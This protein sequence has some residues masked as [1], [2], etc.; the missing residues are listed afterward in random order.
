[1]P[2]SDEQWRGVYTIPVTPFDESGALDRESLRRCVEFCVEAGAHG[3]VMPVNASEFFTLSDAERDEV[4]RLGVKAADGAAPVIAGVSGVSPEHAVERAK[5]AEEAGAD[6][7][8]ALPPARVAGGENIEEYYRVLGEAL[9]VPLFIQ[10][11]NPPAGVPIPVDVMVRLLKE[12]PMIQYLKEETLPPGH[13]FTAVLEQAGDAC[14]GI[15]GGMGGRFLLDEYRR[16]GCGTMPG[17]HITDAHVA[18]WEALERG[19]TPDR[20]TVSEEAR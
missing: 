6:G 5:A 8:I 7:L 15:M 4:V 10:N 13:V 17:C 3:I 14:R 20:Q 18:L 1:M 2:G 11:H 19:R 9:S 16:G 12:V